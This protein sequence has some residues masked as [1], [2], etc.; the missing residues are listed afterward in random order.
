M[1]IFDKKKTGLIDLIYEFNNIPAYIVYFPIG[2]KP[3]TNNR[4]GA[5]T[6]YVHVERS[7]YII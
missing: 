6:N 3:I 5:E 2:N 4:S 7:S 1:T